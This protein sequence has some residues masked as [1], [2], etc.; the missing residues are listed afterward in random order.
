MRGTMSKPGRQFTG[1]QRLSGAGRAGFEL[2]LARIRLGRWRIGSIGANLV[3]PAL[4]EGSNEPGETIERVRY[5]LPRVARRMPFRADCLI[6]A[7][8]AQRWLGQAGIGSAVKIGVRK[9]QR[10]GFEAH[11]WLET[12][13]KVVT[14]WDIEGFDEFLAFTLPRSVEKQGSR[15]ADP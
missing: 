15:L 7:L 10:A 4:S 6:Q 13:G 5:F 3:Q 1:L 2:L 14:G 11:A 9:T 8:A 12:Q